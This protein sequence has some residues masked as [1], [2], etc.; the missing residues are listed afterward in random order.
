MTEI[1]HPAVEYVADTADVVLHLHADLA[2]RANHDLRRGRRSWRADIGDQVADGEVRLVSHSRNRGN[3]ACR[4]RPC[5]DLLVERPQILQ[6]ASAAADE[7]HVVNLPP[8]EMADRCGDLAPGGRTLN[9]HRIN[10]QRQSVESAG[11]DIQDVA[12]RGAGRTGHHRDALRQHRNGLLARRIEEP[13]LSQALLELLEGQLQCAEAG[14]LRGHGIELQ[15]ALLVVDREPAAHDQLQAVLD[16]EAQ[17]SRVAGK[18]HHAH[19]RTAILDRKIEM[20]RGG[21]DEVR[22]LTLHGDVVVAEQIEINLTDQ[23]ADLPD[24][25]FHF[26]S[27]AMN[28]GALISHELYCRKMA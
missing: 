22:H 23:L 8:G 12:D 9:P 21:A 3:G 17:E 27:L 5:H 13:L 2:L 25:L 11:D 26:E 20:T 4:D 24:G 28:S 18:E 15:L 14:G 19:L 7:N 6:R 1:A 10:L 16:S